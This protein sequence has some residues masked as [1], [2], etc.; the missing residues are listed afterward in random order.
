MINKI[1]ISNFRSI[2]NAEVE[3]VPLTILYGPTASG[4]SSLLY[5]LIVLKNFITNPNQQS[6]GFFNLGFMNLGG[7]DNCVFNQKKEKSIDIHISFDDGEYG[8]SLEKSSGDIFLN[9][10]IIRMNA[11]VS[12]PYALNQSFAF[13]IRTNKDKIEKY[14]VNWNGILS[15]VSPEQPTAETQQNAAEISQQLNQ[16]PEYLKKIDIAPHKRGFFKPNYSPTQISPDP[17]SE[18]EV[19]TIIIND[20]NL[21]PKISVDL[22]KILNRDFRTYTA[23]GTATVFF[24]STDKSSRTP[25]YLVNEGFGV[26]QIVYILAKIHRPEIKTILIEE[27]EVHLHPSLIRTLVKTLCSIIKEENKQ[28]VLTTHSEVFVSSLLASIRKKDISPQ[29]VKCYLVKKEG[30]STKFEEQKIGENGQI[31]GGLS[32][33]MEG[34]LEDLKV[35]L[36]KR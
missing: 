19:A 26:N 4:K 36:E 18:D 9:S 5:A 33:F 28:I 17:T 31:A 15:S 3:I 14:N 6:D 20:P 24:Q 7:F 2:E 11:K 8:I 16:I 29:E 10:E 35:F 21:A 13:M 1:K 34:E 30:K 32:S 25:A 22:E 27:P 23:P 12:I